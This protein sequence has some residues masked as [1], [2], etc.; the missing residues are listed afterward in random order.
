VNLEASGMDRRGRPW[1]RPLARLAVSLLF[2][3]VL[4]WQVELQL[5][6]ERLQQLSP[7]LVLFAWAYYALCQLLSSYRW[8]MF[9]TVKN[10]A[11][12]VTSL[13]SYYMIGMFLNN[14]LPGAVGGDAAK[15]YYLYQRSGQGSYA[16]SSVL[17]ERFSGLLGL[18]ILSIAA[19]AVGPP[20]IHKPLVLAS[21]GGSALFL[22]MVA[23]ALWWAP[24]F[25]RI[26]NALGRVLP[27][28]IGP[29]LQRLYGALA[30]YRQHPGMVTRAV[31]LSVVIQGLHALYY[32]VVSWG[33]GLS[34][35]VYY[36]LLFL[37]PVTLAVLAPIS[38]GGLG[39]REAML[40]ILFGQVGV[41]AADILAVSL[42]AHL[43]NTLLSVWG[44]LLLLRRGR[45]ESVP[46]VLAADSPRSVSSVMTG[47]HSQR[48]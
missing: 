13:F 2:L 8:Q 17:L 47:T 18:S 33:L 7:G 42:T 9:L 39:I 15:A 20:W 11:V 28:S 24:L 38:F 21:V 31:A 43:L 30:G 46:A 27:V 41:A 16:L 1:F 26:E 4:L 10:I 44:G 23:L 48:P 32:G 6:V 22:L 25:P 36:F 37:P 40:V 5:V 35:D 3:G 19:L 29:R 14:F 34:I 45:E 12:P